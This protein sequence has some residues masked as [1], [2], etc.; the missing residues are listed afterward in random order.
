MLERQTSLEARLSGV[1]HARVDT[2]L[3]DHDV[4]ASFLRTAADPRSPLSP[5]SA[6]AAPY[7]E[8][9]IAL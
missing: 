8:Q 9:A 2:M 6:D 5:F 4:A 3:G 7:R 1:L